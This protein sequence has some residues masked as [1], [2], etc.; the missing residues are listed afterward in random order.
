M[1]WKWKYYCGR[2]FVT[3]QTIYFFTRDGLQRKRARIGRKCKI[4]NH[5]KENIIF[6]P[7]LLPSFS[8]LIDE[9]YFYHPFAGEWSCYDTLEI[10]GLETKTFCGTTLPAPYTTKLN[11]VKLVMTSDSRIQ[12]SGFDLT[13]TTETSMLQPS[14]YKLKYTESGYINVIIQAV[15]LNKQKDNNI[16]Y[17]TNML[18]KTLSNDD[19]IIH[20]IINMCID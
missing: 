6:R 17:Y 13:L 11:V 9:L 15:L 12:G 1:R 2:Y 19:L 7:I 10:K 14:F 5:T 4:I 20:S 16:Y 18:L 3:R 8:I